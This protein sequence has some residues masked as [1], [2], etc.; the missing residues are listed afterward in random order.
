MPITTNLS[1][2]RLLTGDTNATD[3]LLTDD[4]VNFLIAA[5][6][7]LDVTPATVNVPAAAADAAAAIA[8]KFSRN[9]NFAEDGQRFDVAQRV[10]HYLALE[11]SLRRRAGGT[12]EPY[13]RTTT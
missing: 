11:M 12:S 2:V 10:S 3:P 8:A 5:R 4:E 6:T 9:F 7:D 1:R 13:A